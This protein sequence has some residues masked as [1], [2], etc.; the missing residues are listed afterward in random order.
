MSKERSVK[1]AERLQIASTQLAAILAC[2]R[3]FDGCEPPSVGLKRARLALHYA[4]LLIE[5]HDRT[6]AEA[7]AA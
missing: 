7:G 2:N 1:N 5:E 3:D 4:D 6:A